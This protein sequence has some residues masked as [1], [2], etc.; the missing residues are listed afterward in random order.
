[1]LSNKLLLGIFAFSAQSNLSVEERV[2]TPRVHLPEPATSC[3]VFFLF[4]SLAVLFL[5][6]EPLSA[7]LEKRP[8]TH[9][10]YVRPY[11]IYK[12]A[13]LPAHPAV[14]FMLGGVHSTA[15]SE[16]QEFGWIE[17]ADRHGFIAVFPELVATR[18]DLPVDR[19]N[20]TFWE[21]KGSRTHLLS[22]GMLPVDDD[23]Y[24][25]SVLH[26]VVKQEHIDRNRVFL[27]GFSSG[28]GMAQL[29]A[30]RHSREITAIAAA[31]TPLMDPPSRL[32][33]P[34]SVLYLHGD[35]DEQLSG[36]EVNSP[37]F[38]T[39][40]HGN[41]VTWGYLDGCRRQTAEKTTWG[42]QFSWRD[43]NHLVSVVADFVANLGHEWPSSSNSSWNP[44][45]SSNVSPDFTEMAWQFF[46]TAQRK[47]AKNQ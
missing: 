47:P 9:N 2:A 33:C 25:I 12:P 21:M 36:F 26:E 19:H 29:F 34:V 40:P 31:A 41:W 23:G 4:I 5:C 17:E 3:R 20:V 30:S 15:L 22:P 39:T 43:C 8:F 13:H 27:A 11:L 44:K 6:V 37:D 28:S 10:G 46:S 32:V 16:S 45:K 7:Q 18:P 42:V 24:L 1:M 38:A 35:N 14:V